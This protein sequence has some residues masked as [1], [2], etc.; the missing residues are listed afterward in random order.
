[1]SA[2]DYEL[3]DM[4]NS[5]VKKSEKFK[6]AAII[7]GAVLGAGGAV[8]YGADHISHLGDAPTE[9]TGADDIMAGARAGVVDDATL[10][11]APAA[12]T[13]TAT[14]APAQTHNVHVYQHVVDEPVQ[15]EPDVDI[16]QSTVIYDEEGNVLSSYDMGTIDGKDFT[17]LDTDGD[18]MADVFAYDV[19]GNGL[20]EQDEIVNAEN[21]NYVMGQGDHHT[22]LVVNTDPI[23]I[24]DPTPIID[25]PGP[26][27]DISD[28]RNDFLDE[29]TGEVY[30]DD[31]AENNPDYRND[32]EEPRGQYMAYHNEKE[33]VI[34]NDLDDVD[35][36]AIDIHAG[37]DDVLDEQYAY[38]DDNSEDLYGEDTGSNED[39]AFNDGD[40]DDEYDAGEQ[41]YAYN[42]ESDNYTD[43]SFSDDTY[44]D[45]LA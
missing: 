36:D 37:Q 11:E 32:G 40:V 19:N 41:D 20:Y 22:E 30:K 26:G 29:K 6:K 38:N 15:Q 24:D 12:P 13:E 43:D 17:I 16:N 28:I 8:A 4:E 25:N 27:E 9:S 31:W 42:D 21:M 23:I 45:G 7:G 5:A 10:E 18:G 35:D 33:D 14:A 39:Y 34:V 2:N 44:D 3:E 1:M